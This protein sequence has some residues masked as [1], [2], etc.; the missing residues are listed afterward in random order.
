MIRRNAGETPRA[1]RR[2]RSVSPETH[3]RLGPERASQSP[4][5]GSRRGR[6]INKASSDNSTRHEELKASIVGVSVTTSPTTK[7]YVQATPTQRPQ[8]AYIS[9]QVEEEE[10]AGTTTLRPSNPGLQRP[11]HNYQKIN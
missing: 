7:L 10:D 8:L 2:S 9:K 4:K 5:Q 3:L 11:S 1:R 6:N